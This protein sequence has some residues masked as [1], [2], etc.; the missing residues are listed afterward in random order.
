M[1]RRLPDGIIDKLVCSETSE[2][3]IAQLMPV[4]AFHPSPEAAERFGWGCSS[5]AYQ[6]R[7]LSR[8]GWDLRRLMGCISDDVAQMSG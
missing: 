1:P 2:R 6:R 5:A 7:L 3:V 8:R 4:G